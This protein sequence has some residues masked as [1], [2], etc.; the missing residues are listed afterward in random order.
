MVMAAKK[1]RKRK[2]ARTPWEKPAPRKSKHT[3]LTSGDKATAK[4]RA[5][6]AGRPYPNLV[7]NMT[8]AKEKKGGRKKAAK[9]GKK[10]SKG[11]RRKASR[12]GGRTAST[13]GRRKA[14]P[15]GRRTLMAQTERAGGPS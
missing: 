15:G 9:G 12:G 4:K 11:G 6:K 10:A 3:T 1:S 8:V 5:K 14:S 7:D 2:S 13:G